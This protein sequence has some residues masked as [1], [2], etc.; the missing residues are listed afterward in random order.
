MSLRYATC[1]TGVPALPAGPPYPCAALLPWAGLAFDLPPADP[2]L[3]V[4][5]DGGREPTAPLANLVGAAAAWEKWPEHMDF[6]DP[7]SPM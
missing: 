1:S 7:E 5:H 6:L 2:R 4:L 3:R